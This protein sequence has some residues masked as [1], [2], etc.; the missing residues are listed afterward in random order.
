MGSFGKKHD[1]FIS[2]K[3]KNVDMARLISDRLIYSGKAVWFNE[4]QVLLVERSRFQEAIDQGIRESSFGLALTNDDYAKSKYCDKEMVQLLQFCGPNNILEVKIPEEPGTHEKYPQ[5]SGSPGHTFT[6]NINHLLDFVAKKTGWEIAPPVEAIRGQ[7][8]D[9]FEGSCLGKTYSLDVSGWELVR[10][11]FYGGGPCYVMNVEGFDIFW[12]LQYG[13]EYSPKAYEARIGLREKDDRDL[14]NEI[15]DYANHYFSQLKKGSRVV[16]V[17]LLFKEGISHFSVTYHDGTFWKRR[18][19]LMLRHPATN[20]IAEFVFTFQFP[21][22]YRQ[23]CRYVE[24]MDNLVQTLQWGESKEPIKK[25][26]LRRQPEKP[27]LREEERPRII[28]D[29]AM[30]DKF[31]NEGLILAKQGRLREAIAAWETVLKHTTLAGLRGMVLFNIGRAYEKMG[32]LAQAIKVYKRSAEANP[33]QFNALSNIGSIYLRQNNPKEAMPYLMKAV[34]KNPNDDIT[35]KN[36]I[37]CHER[38]GNVEEA[39]FW[40]AVLSRIER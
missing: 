19:S 10:R 29:K 39:E 28:E 20:L 35:I 21:G 2:Y 24:L 38:L 18:Y 31:N 26:T 13:E 4:Y 12:N 9:V 7:R 37:F 16:G 32:D 25:D 23:Y 33:L 11:S 30:A 15:C 22:S 40:K 27:S 17:H 36:L 3:S 6:G 5:L 1:V 14:Y 34:E 8:K